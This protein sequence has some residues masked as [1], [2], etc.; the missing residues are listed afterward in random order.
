MCQN[1]LFQIRYKIFVLDEGLWQVKFMQL[2]S[3]S[4]QLFNLD[5]GEDISD[6]LASNWYNFAIT[7]LA[8]E[9][10]C[11]SFSLLRQSACFSILRNWVSFKLP[12]YFSCRFV[13]S[14]SRSGYNF[15]FFFSLKVL[16][17]IIRIFLMIFMFLLL[18]IF[19]LLLFYFWFRLL[20]S[21]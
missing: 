15:W 3:V 5:I 14:H 12:L 19:G 1:D 18:I 9:Q 21:W 4:P 8:F 10:R 6:L 20:L 11:P 7:C 2:F 17:R 13:F 16:E